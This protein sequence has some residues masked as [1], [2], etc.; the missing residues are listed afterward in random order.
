[1][2]SKTLLDTD[3]LSLLLRQQTLVMNRATQYLSIYPKYTF[4]L[5]TR[6]EILRGLKAKNAQKQ[7]AAFDAFCQRSEILPVNESVIYLA[8]DVYA[9]LYQRGQL[10]SDADLLIAATALDQGL[11]L[12]TNNENHFSRVSGLAIDNWSKT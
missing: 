2:M 9:Y 5:I 7:L 6:Y 12:A 11:V 1:M 8:S 10:I 3:I 4:S